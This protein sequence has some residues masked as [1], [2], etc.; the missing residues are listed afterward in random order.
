MH[1]RWIRQSLELARR[2]AGDVSPNPMVGAVI[3]GEDGEV[4]GEGWHERFGEAHAEPN[5][6]A[7]AEEA[8]SS[9][10]LRKATLYVNLEPCSHHGKTPPCAELIVEKQI[11]RVVVG[12]QDPNPKVSGSGLDRL[13][14]AGVEVTTGVLEAEC[15]RLNE[16][17]THHLQRGRPLL[18]LKVAQT[19]D[20]RVA[21]STGDSRWVSGK[22][23]RTL[24]HRWRAELD[25]VLVGSGT[26][27]ADDPALTVRHAW[28]GQ[29]SGLEERQPRRV[30]LDR[31]GRLPPSLQLF[32]DAHVDQTVVVVSEEAAPPYQA[33]LEARGGQ[34]LRVPERSG[35]L[36]L[37]VLLERLGASDPPVQSL[38]VEAGPGLA[39]AL[40]R[41]GLVDR[42]FCFVAPKV[43][44]EGVPVVGRLGI[45][46]MNK[47]L[48]FAE[49]GWETIGEDLL[50]RGY[51]HSTGN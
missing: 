45:T 9:A 41:E 8:Y 10:A 7:A 44:G 17:F 16:A 26:A 40:F 3:V 1:E 29:Q 21:T 34:V 2:G 24:V 23:S 36:D 20:G 51:M 28:P 37:H 30:V 33:E 38:L 49:H 12:M 6:I 35:H 22:A 5:A 50:F 47:A 31:E 4:L 19:L 11:P 46:Q 32:S 48:T 27:R 25:A 39:T 18:T 15:R 13:R 14:A 43:V 42:F